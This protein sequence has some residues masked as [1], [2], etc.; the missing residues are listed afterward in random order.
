MFF[1][2]G[3]SF[4]HFWDYCLLGHYFVFIGHFW[5]FLFWAFCGLFLI[6]SRLLERQMKEM[7]FFGL[8]ICLKGGTWLSFFLGTRSL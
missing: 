3:D 7:V 1:F 8:L 4:E 5:A 2:S 6:F